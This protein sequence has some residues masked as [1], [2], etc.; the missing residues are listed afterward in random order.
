MCLRHASLTKSSECLFFFFS[1]SHV[2]ACINIS[3]L[4]GWTITNRTGSSSR[5]DG[6]TW[7]EPFV[8]NYLIAGTQFA[9][10]TT[11]RLQ[12]AS[13]EVAIPASNVLKETFEIDKDYGMPCGM[14]KLWCI[15]LP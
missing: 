7:E 15:W 11:F 4:I 13:L 14:C 3:E 12:K 1:F 6:D 5:E 8:A 10:L 9:S 2:N